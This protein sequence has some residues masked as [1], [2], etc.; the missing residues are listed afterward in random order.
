MTRL[1]PALLFFPL[2]LPLLACGGGGTVG[3]DVG[4]GT[5][6]ISVT[7]FQDDNRNGRRD[8][9]E[10][11]VV[12]DVDIEVAGRTAR[13]GRGTGLATVTGVA[14]G[15]HAVGIRAA[16]LPPYYVPGAA[17]TVEAPQAAA[18]SVLVPVVLPIGGNGPGEV[19]ASGDSI[20]QGFGSSDGLG[21]RF[22]L[23]QSLQG[24]FAGRTF[25]VRYP[26]GDGETST[27][28]AARIEGDL[29][30]VRP[31]YTLLAWGVNDFLTSGCAD[32]AAASC[33]LIPNLQ[34]MIRVVRARESLPCLATLPAANTAYPDRSPPER[35][36]WVRAA[37]DQ[38]R[39]LA[40][41]ERVLLVDV[42]AAFF[43][44]ADLSRLFFDHVHPNSTGYQLISETYFQALTRGVVAP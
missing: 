35:N 13:S 6:T 23:K 32:P 41:R 37:N 25:N 33:P 19:L 12:P 31:A 22:T 11:A 14:A 2:A 1:R 44:E 24:F 10:T 3:P 27:G 36:N 9:E 28:G 40:G 4:A 8:P 20:S 16:S 15:T 18:A 30:A 5:H 26:G 29:A 42:G 43:R 7:V 38:I 17:M 34:A 39:A 21:F